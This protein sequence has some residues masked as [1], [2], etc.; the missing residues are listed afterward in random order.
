MPAASGEE[1]GGSRSDKIE[2]NE[3][4]FT[5][6]NITNHLRNAKQSLGFTTIRLHLLFDKSGNTLAK[7]NGGRGGFSDLCENGKQPSYS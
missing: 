2:I 6:E 4:G 7:I 1:R 5:G 3:K